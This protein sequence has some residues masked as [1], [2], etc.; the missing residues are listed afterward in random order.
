M[1][2]EVANQMDSKETQDP[3]NEQETT[4]ENVESTEQNDAAET[5]EEAA[6]A[7]EDELTRLKKENEAL[8]DKFLRLYSEFENF[9]RRT[10]KEKVEMMSS[11]SG[12]TIE[13]ILPVLD[14]LD[15]AGENNKNATDIEA[16]RSGFELIEHK[17]RTILST[18]GVTAMEAKGKVFD[19][20]HHEAITKIPAPE[21]DLKGK[22]VDVVEAGYFLNDKVLRYAKVVVGE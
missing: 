21:E 19:V 5:A 11:A 15:R 14:D 13:K 6:P 22:V 9:R 20:D 16:V 10:A 7:E 12:S 8:N 18:M 17:M 1:R 4:S 2:Y 3:V